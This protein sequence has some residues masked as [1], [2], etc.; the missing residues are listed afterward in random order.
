MSVFFIFITRADMQI[1]TLYGFDMYILKIKSSKPF[2][3][4]YKQYDVHIC[5]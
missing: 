1:L 4:S 5:I 2:M 3:Y